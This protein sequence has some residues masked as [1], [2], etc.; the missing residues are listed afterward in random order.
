MQTTADIN[1]YVCH[2]GVPFTAAEA[3]DIRDN[4]DGHR[5]GGADRFRPRGMVR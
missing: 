5:R 3:A 2:R 1:P 4:P